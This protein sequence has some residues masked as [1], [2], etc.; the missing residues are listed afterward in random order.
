MYRK[1]GTKPT[2]GFHNGAKK[3]KSEPLA[4]ALARIEFQELHPPKN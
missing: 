3:L 2:R 1:A 4:L